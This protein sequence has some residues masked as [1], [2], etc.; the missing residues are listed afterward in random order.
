MK[1]YRYDIV[2]YATTDEFGDLVKPLFPNPKVSLTTYD[3]IKETPKGH[4]IGFGGPDWLDSTLNW[5]RWVSKTSRKRFAHPTKEQAL[6]SF[7][8]RQE[9]KIRILKN[10]TLNSEVA[11]GKAQHMLLKLE[12][13]E[14]L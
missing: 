7:I 3:L 9:A 8:K 2:N 4:W 1:F 11:L 12:E 13:N 5:K 10:Q 6:I 14:K